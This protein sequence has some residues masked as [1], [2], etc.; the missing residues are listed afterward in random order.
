MHALR[1]RAAEGARGA[2]GAVQELARALPH[3]QCLAHVSVDFG[4]TQVTNGS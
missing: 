1:F 2:E 3:A 4:Q